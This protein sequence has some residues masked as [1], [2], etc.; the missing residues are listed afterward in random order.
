VTQS[1]RLARGRGAFAD[2]V[3][4]PGLLHGRVLRSP[5]PHA[6][7]L[8]IDTASARALPGVAA[9][10]TCENVPRVAVPSGG[11]WGAL[12]AVVDAVMLDRKVRFVG[13]RVAAVAAEDPEI[14][15]RACEAIRVDYEVLPAVLDPAE[16]LRPGASVL[17]DD[18]D[19]HGIADASRNLASEVRVEV[20]DVAAALASAE[21]V[22][23]TA[24][25]VS[26]VAVPPIE[27][28]LAITW[29]DDDQRLVVRS[30]TD[31]PFHVRRV[32]AAQL[33]IPSGWIRVVP[34]RV[35]GG[36]GAKQEVLVED[37]CAMLT[38]RT[39]RP[40]RLAL[41]RHEERTAA[42]TRP[43]IEI[44]IRSGVTDGR[45]TAIELRALLNCG[46]YGGNAPGLLRALAAQSLSHY[47]CANL[48]F[49]GRAAYTSRCPAGATRGYGAPA[50]HFALESH[51]DEVAVA[52]GED[53]LELRRRNH[54]REEDESPMVAAL[55]GP[56]VAPRDCGLAAA[57]EAGAREIGWSRRWKA[58]SSRSGPLR[59]GIGAALAHHRPGFGG[60]E[61]GAASLSLTED[62]SL[63]LVTGPSEMGASVGARAIAAAVLGLPVERVI[64]RAADTDGL[65]FTPGSRAPAPFAT[66]RA[67]ERAARLVLEQVLRT[68]ARLLGAEAGDLVARDGRVGSAN[69]RSLSLA[70][71]ALASLHGDEPSPIGATAFYQA[72]EAPPS[73]AAAFAEVEVDVETG[74]VRVLKVVEAV[75]A[76]PGPNGDGRAGQAQIEGDAVA[77][78]AEAF[79]EPK[80]A[81]PER[82]RTAGAVR[83]HALAT[84]LD[85]PEIVALLAPGRAPL[86]DKELGEVTSCPV[87]PAVANAVAHAT[88]VRVRDLPLSPD[89]VLAA[90]ERAQRE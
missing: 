1:G 66:G 72:R 48:R 9:V 4:L 52:L 15:Q 65:P 31:T 3:L 90:L 22:F 64:A 83:E 58:A 18:P 23:E 40:V 6:R 61:R 13:D 70:E 87:A 67:V 42:P 45:F 27:P 30:S 81:E 16:A 71:I 47:R 17:H 63:S 28:H 26:P 7:I 33:G 79:L 80:A 76:G 50:G 56:P 73:F 59:R 62:G 53:P 78:L 14:A 74:V 34:P 49:E 21:R 88:G 39:G 38:L 2:D 5:H 10:L 11:P 69:G 19:A 46:A 43:G 89:R 68:A 77:A 20:G 54:V 24:H 12:G 25:R 60:D 86:G 51:V 44:S 84:A 37:L 75:D 8:R 55:G 85:T 36:L 29:L 57:I 32:L 41:S 35:G 82:A